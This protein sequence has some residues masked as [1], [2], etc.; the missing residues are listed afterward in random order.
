[1]ASDFVLRGARVYTVDAARSW[2]EA[3]AVK[4]GRIVF[5]GTTKA[6]APWIGPNTKVLDLTGRMVVPGFIDAHVHPI[7]G[8]IELGQCD[9]NGLATAEAIFEKVRAC[10]REKP[11]DGWLVGG[12]W[13]LPSFPGGAPTRQQLDALVSARPV[14]LSAADGHSAWVNTKGLEAAGVTASTSDPKDGRIEREPD[15]RPAGTLREDAMGLVSR[16]L[17]KPDRAERLAG[18]R[19]ALALL[20]RNGVTGL[21]EASA[22]SG[23]EGSAARETLET[24]RDLERRGELTAR[25]AVALGTDPARGPEQVDDLVRLRRDYASPRVRPVAVKIFEDGVIE[26]RTAAMLE[27]YLDREGQRGEPVFDESR[28]PPLVERLA[29]EGFNVHV[30]A[31][32]DRAVRV[33]LDAMEAAR[34]SEGDTHP[35]HQL[36]HLEVIHPDDVPRFRTLGVVANFQPLWA[37]PD[38]YITDLTWPALGPERSRWLYP[39]GSVARSGA[40]LA[41]GS[42]WSVSSLNPLE[43]I[44]VAVTRKAPEG[45][46]G[47]PLLPEEALGLPEA[48]AAYT[49][50]AAYAC[51]FEKETGSIEVGKSA[52]LAVLDRDVFAHPAGEIGKAK[53][54]LTL[55][56]GRAVYEEPAPAR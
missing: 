4:D 51:G 1:M 15:G 21:Q 43:G 31:I 42:D 24:Y 50:G 12:G 49:I 25:V 7:S 56:E 55:L 20:N 23:P 34:G 28:M 6:A 30:H 39:I 36:A 8:G 17:P 14:F 19:R 2:A 40:V 35:R 37:Y 46:P 26:A 52:D 18:L 45:E 5:V 29:R 48:L 38:K 41:F 11:G 32:G 33:T 9:L 27:P 3:V 10:D 16:L 53:V 22:G 47:E 44:Q 13:G 54:L